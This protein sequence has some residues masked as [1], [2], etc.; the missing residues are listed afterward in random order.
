MTMQHMVLAKKVVVPIVQV[1]CVW[2][3]RSG[4]E[5]LYGTG[6]MSKL[7]FWITLFVAFVTVRHARV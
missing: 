2:M 4:C 6:Y 3:V 1:G 7:V 5:T